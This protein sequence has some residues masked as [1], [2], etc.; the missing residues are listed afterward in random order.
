MRESFHQV[1]ERLAAIGRRKADGSMAGS[2]MVQFDPMEDY[3][4]TVVQGKWRTKDDRVARRPRPFFVHA[5]TPK[6][7]PATIFDDGHYV[8]PVR[9][10]KGKYTRPWT[11]PEDMVDDL[12]GVQFE[13]GFWKEIRG[14]ACELEDKFESWKN[15]S[16]ICERV[17][18]YYEEVFAPFEK[19]KGKG[20]KGSA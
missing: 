8:D 15:K 4:L 19:G 13:M 11:I 3:Q 2:A 17:R 12:G 16:G 7:N 6:F 10:E 18:K 1:S 5:N 9:D 20:A 14:V